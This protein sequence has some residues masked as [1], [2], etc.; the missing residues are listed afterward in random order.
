MSQRSL[1]LLSNVEQLLSRWWPS[2]RLG[3]DPLES[4][5]VDGRYAPVT[6]SNWKL[7]PWMR[8]AIFKQRVARPLEFSAGRLTIVIPF[9]D[10]EEHLRRLLPPLI[11]VLER[12]QIQHQ[13]LVV[14]QVVPGLFNR[15]RL[16]NIGMHYAADRSDY[17][18]LHDVDAIPV[19]ANYR[20]PSQ[21]LRLVNA[22]VRSEGETQRSPHY[23]S[24][25][26][27]VRKEHAFAANGFSNLYWGWG[28]EDDDFFFRLLLAGFLCYVDTEGR[29]LDLPNPRVIRTS[30]A[31]KL[32]HT[33][34]NRKRRSQLVRGCLDPLDD[35][36]NTLK[37][38]VLERTDLGQ[39]KKV[40]V[41]WST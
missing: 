4:L 9:R 39:Y 21:P 15:G 33:Q 6:I 23:F 37:Y 28:K 13:V 17:Y 25:A 22:I 8:R 32:T 38:E 36:L 24:G 40:R 12:Q 7:T 16:L 30:S 29:Y 34:Q 35:G 10:R 14:E 3:S 5:R 26:V 27:S 19:H 11:D 2:R 31:S 18:C 41:S 1:L 20:C